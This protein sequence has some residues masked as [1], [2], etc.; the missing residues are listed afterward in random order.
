[1]NRSKHKNK[2]AF[3]TRRHNESDWIPFHYQV[4]QTPSE[5]NRQRVVLE[6]SLHAYARSKSV[7]YSEHLI[8][9]QSKCIL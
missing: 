4:W 3:R 5:S 9:I 2:P 8:S 1:M 6:A 7:Y